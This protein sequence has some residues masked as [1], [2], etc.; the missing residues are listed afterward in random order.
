MAGKLTYVEIDVDRCGLTYGSAP[1][2][3]SIPTTGD[4]K[5]FNSIGTCQDRDN[6]DDDVVTIR[7]AVN[8]V[9]LPDDIECI[10]C[11][12]G[13]SD[14]EFTPSIVSLG[15]DLG[16]RASL[17]VRM[18]DHPD[19]DTGPAGDKYLS[20][21]VYDPFK[22]GTFFGKF[23]ARHPYLRGRNLRVIRGEV[24]QSLGE[25]ETRH[26]II[27]SFDG[28]LPDGTFSIIA[29][30]VL[31]LADGDRAQAP[32]ASN[33][34]LTAGINSSAMAFTLA[35][36]GIG[37]AEYPASGLGAIGGKEIVAY[38]RSGN[39]V[40]I[41]AR[42]QYGTTAVAH[43][44]QDR[45]QVVI[46]YDAVDP[47]NIVADLLENYADVSSSYI[48]IADWLDETGAFFDRL[49]TA[50][51]PEPT[52]VSKL[53]SEVIEQA[54]LAVWW[55]DSQQKIKLQVLRAIST[56]A[57]RFSEENTLEG[58]IQSKEQPDKRVSEV[59][60]YFGQNNPLK[61]VD[62][63]DNYR[64]I[65]T[66]KDDQSAADYG[67]PAIKKI[68]SRWMPPFGRTVATRNGQIILGR[69]KNPP[70]RLNF[71]VFRDGVSLPD[72][73]QGARVGAW[74][75]QDDTGAPADVPIQ[76][77]RIN[78]TADRFKVEGE[79][80]LFDVPDDIDDRTI[81]I[82]ADALNIN[83]RTVY[84]NIYGVP[85][86]GEEIDCIVQAGVVVG[87][88]STGTPA[89]DLGS[90]PTQAATGN[91]TSGSPILTG[92]S[93]DANT[94]KVGMVV[95]GTGIPAKSKILTIDSSSQITLD[96]NATSGSSTSTA[97]TI[98]T[99]LLSVRVDGSIIGRG[100]S[101][102]K[103]GDGQPS[104]GGKNGNPGGTALRT[105]YE[106]DL[107]G[108]GVIGG[109]GGGAGGGSYAGTFYGGGGGGGGQGRNGG[110]GGKKGSGT[111]SD[112]KEGAAGT[113]TA[114][115]S[116]GLGGADLTFIAGGNG[117]ALGQAGANGLGT[118]PG[119]GA[120]GGRS[121]DGDSFISAGG[122]ITYHGS[123]IN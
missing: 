41:T 76:F 60:I 65:E 79:E 67:S 1:C 21:R 88:I 58:T 71:D 6:F 86:H 106:F 62:E 31:K 47:A 80:M 2:T 78:P 119:N 100:G 94:L 57:S 16:Q 117:G 116:G 19:A 45:F 4:R 113:L 34:F 115:G 74:F 48:P 70:R 22:Q 12:R 7:F 3:A 77:T 99:V 63:A 108:S 84:E 42:A 5:C 97:L 46:H 9:Y 18:V 29:K 25:M 110:A 39:S 23:R 122:T 53:L 44:A 27:D 28:P 59:I 56:D 75:I 17:K 96:K 93:I 30:D 118:N 13:E 85:V 49:F 91:R 114:P 121:V 54:A 73:G 102:G 52:D 68:F 24:G 33:G 64:S 55:D 72:L 50:V 66:V 92:L 82:D 89:F 11:I 95:R 37:D 81:I 120:V 32:R 38:T 105:Q 35:P 10:P 98:A 103:G 15:V 69:Y 43:D 104:D 83:L 107:T 111:N 87:S 14:I 26:F 101:G 90:W 109:G 36:A 51:I 112:G 40:T 61:P 8:T 20:D 123:K